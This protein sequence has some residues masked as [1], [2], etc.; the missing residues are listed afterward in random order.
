[1]YALLLGLLIASQPELRAQ[2]PSIPLA[3]KLFEARQQT[4]VIA[5]VVIVSDA[6]SF[7]AAL[8]AWD[9]QRRFPVLWDDGSIRAREDIARFVRA[10]EPE[11]VLRFECAQPEPF[12]RAAAERIARI[13]RTL[14]RA[15]EIKEVE[16][17]REMVDALQES[18]Q[19]GPGLVISDVNG[20][21][22]P[23]ALALAAGRHQPIA[24]TSSLGRLSS[25]LSLKQAVELEHF[26]RAYLEHLELSWS[27]MG[28]EI[29][30]I[31]LALECP[32]K[33][34]IDE[35]P[36]DFL[37]TTDFI[38]RTDPPGRS[39]WA[40]TGLL[41]GDEARSTYLAMC[42][43][44][45]T[46]KSAWLFDGYPA[47]AP[48]EAY[49]CSAASSIFA[50]A[51]WQTVVHDVPRNGLEHWRAACVRPVDAGF[52]LVNTRGNADFFRLNPG[53]A[54]PGDV[55]ILNQPAAV[56]FVHS[57]S[58]ARA[59]NIDTVAGR[60]LEHGAYLYVGS[61]QEPTL[62]GFVPTPRV[63][64]RALAG[65]PLSAAARP[66]SG[67]PWKIVFLGDPLATLSPVQVR[68]QAD[69]PLEDTTDLAE[70]ARTLVA[71]HKYAPAMER[72]ALLARNEDIVRLVRALREQRPDAFDRDVARVALLPLFRAGRPQ[73]VIDC[74]R[75]LSADDQ[76]EPAYLD[77]LWLAARLRL[78]A[79]TDVADLLR[80]H[81]REDQLAA[82][83]IELSAAIAHQHGS[84]AA[85][86]F[87]QSV[88][89]RMN[90]DRDRRKIERQTKRLLSNTSP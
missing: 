28:D 56:H 79:R 5:S 88:L 54:A 68:I 51:A 32:A 15:L 36:A 84:H 86:G 1:M 74:F 16:S 31:T 53:D 35:Q 58:A 40:Y 59:G 82:D 13:E 6:P 70:Q 65:L 55:P 37:A 19:L 18:N 71:Q 80:Q 21:L 64:Q 87:L 73:E 25:A 45:L 22:W 44:F 41:F 76:K 60:W 7:L 10:F 33:V 66:D 38:G 83:A 77:A 69:I 81:L 57:F 61:V 30:A 48:W 14:F 23:G 43:L 42:S 72:F 20:L 8:S 75:N 9:R 46:P 52:V 85:V 2:P 78:Y 67:P 50:A 17:T 89:P 49:D 11:T 62:G 63:A 47:E 12:P 39:R 90:N 26:A 24:F 3:Q 4:H 34:R 27:L 29:D